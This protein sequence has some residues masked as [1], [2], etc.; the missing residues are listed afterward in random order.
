MKTPAHNSTFAI[1]GVSRSTD[2][3]V[4]TIMKYQL[5]LIL[6]TFGCS[7]LEQNDFIESKEVGKTNHGTIVY[8]L[9]QTGID[10]YR[11]EF[12]LVDKV[13]TTDIFE[14]HLNEATYHNIRFIVVENGDTTKIKSNRDFWHLSKNIGDHVFTLLEKTDPF[15]DLGCTAHGESGRIIQLMLYNDSIKALSD[16]ETLAHKKIWDLQ[17]VDSIARQLNELN[18]MT[19]TFIDGYPTKT[20]NHFTVKFGQV[21][22][23][24]LPTI[25][26][27]RV[28][29]TSGRVDRVEDSLDL[30]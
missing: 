3:L 26:K 5:L 18:T 17:E 4:V 24:Q 6:L 19:Y 22:D 29:I 12:C 13:D 21:S 20:D 1:G 16:L 14:T 2:S 7:P 9:Y 10:S 25:F 23:E 30:K 11:Y 27:Y 8:K 28:D 15:K